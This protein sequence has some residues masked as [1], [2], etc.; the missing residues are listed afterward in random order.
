MVKHKEKYFDRLMLIF[1]MLGAVLSGYYLAEIINNGSDLN[2]G[3]YLF[4][5]VYFVV[6]LFG[7]SRLVINKFK[8]Q[9]SFPIWIIA[10]I[11]SGI[12]LLLCST[13][14]I[15][16]TNKTVDVKLTAI[17]ENLPNDDNAASEVWLLDIILDGKEQDLSK[18]G[19][20]E[21]WFYRDG[22]I[23]TTGDAAPL[24]LRISYKNEA[25]L[26]LLKHSWSGTVQIEYPGVNEQI[27]LYNE[28]GIR[29]TIPL[30]AS[31]PSLSFSKIIVLIGAFLLFTVLH[32]ISLS[33]MLKKDKL[34]VGTWLLTGLQLI[35]CTIGAA[36][37]E[38]VFIL[39]LFV[40]FPV[41]MIWNVDYKKYRDNKG[42]S[43]FFELCTLYF[44]FALFANGLFLTELAV[45]FT[46]NRILF[47][48]LAFWAMHPCGYLILYVFDLIS[49]RIQTKNLEKPKCPPGR[50]A[51]P[52]HSLYFLSF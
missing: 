1:T 17:T 40:L 26:V 43:I 48:C 15:P 52:I 20:T 16:K 5:F 11:F 7:L 9:F 28:T 24:N 51:P 33:I 27:N 10:G 37:R 30:L 13:T 2:K 49:S 19:L 4:V 38:D 35:I 12:L 42:L 23:I 18:V 47:F 3:Q 8:I 36:K 25:E 46:F 29:E 41:L 22:D 50:Q 31:T 34:V 6:L 39:A 44:T 21:G 32:A 45:T 14:L